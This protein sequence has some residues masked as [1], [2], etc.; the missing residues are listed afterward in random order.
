MIFICKKHRFHN[1][2]LF[3]QTVYTNL[4]TLRRE[5][6]CVSWWECG[7]EES[8]RDATD[9]EGLLDTVECQDKAFGAPCKVRTNQNLASA[10]TKQRRTNLI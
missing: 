7:L 4:K 8:P 10:S 9:P 2:N 1:E 5:G 6:S 3:E